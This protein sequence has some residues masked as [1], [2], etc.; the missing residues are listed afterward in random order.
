MSDTYDA[1]RARA[2]YAV[3]F[4][5]FRR[6]VEEVRRLWR[7]L[8]EE[9]ARATRGASGA[10]SAGGGSRGQ[11]EAQAAARAARESARAQETAAQAAARRRREE[12]QLSEALARAARAEQQ[13][14]TEAQ[15]T[16]RELE[17]TA[18]AA[19]RR[20]QAEER[21]RRLRERPAGPSFTDFL[22]ETAGNFGLALGAGAVVAAGVDA[23]RQALE[24]QRTQA[25]LR[26][27][28]T[29][30]ELYNETIRLAAE[31][32]R[33]FGGSLNANLAPLTSLAL[34]AQ[35][36]GVEIS[37]LNDLSQRL[38]L[39][40]PEQGADGAGVALREALSGDTQSLVE[41]FEL[42]RSALVAI[43]D[44][45]ATAAER[46][47]VVDQVLRDLNVT[48]DAVRGSIPQATLAFN[49]LNAELDTL[50]ITAGDGLTDA[51]EESAR[52][53]ARL[54]G[55]VNDNPQA[56][57]ELRALFGGGPVNLGG[58]ERDLARSRAASSLGQVGIG[59]DG[60]GG[61]GAGVGIQRAVQ[62]TLGGNA[63]I[64]QLATDISQDIARARTLEAS[65]GGGA[66]LQEAIDRS[67]ALI[68]VSDEAAAAVL[69]VNEQF[70]A[71]GDAE[72]YQRALSELEV[73][74]N[75]LRGQEQVV[76][77]I[78]AAST[79][80]AG[81]LSIGAVG[82]ADL[83]GRLTA[84]AGTSDANRLAVLSL[85]TGYR[86]GKLTA[87]ELAAATTALEQAQRQQAQGSEEA[88][89]ATAGLTE[90]QRARILAELEGE[91]SARQLA[92]AQATI[93]SLGGQVR[94]GLITAAEGADIIANR[95]GFAAD[96]AQRLIDRSAAAA[97]VNNVPANLRQYQS[98]GVPQ[99]VLRAQQ[100]SQESQRR[101]Q[102]AEEARR[103]QL[104]A[105][106]SA[107]DVVADRQRRYNEAV[108]QYG[109]R[110]AEAIR[111]E[112]AL[113]QARER[114]AAE[115]ERAA[116][117]GTSAAEKAARATATTLGRIEDRT[118]DHYIRLLQ[119]QEDF[120]RRSAR[121]QEDYELGRSRRQE[122]FETRRQRL[123][124]EGQIFEARQLEEEFRREEER[125]RQDFERDRAR[126]VDDFARQQARQAADLGLDTSRI[127]DR[128]ALR[129]VALPGDVAGGAPVVAPVVVPSGVLPESVGSAA[130]AAAA[131]GL[132]RV[133]FA[134]IS[135]QLDSETVATAVYPAIEQQLDAAL[136]GGIQTITVTAPPA[137]GQSS[138]V[139]GAR[140]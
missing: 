99:D 32:Q 63:G 15:R 11:S 25:T 24:L 96:E 108:K 7:R 104:L 81:D 82:A 127:A 69:R 87:D 6:D 3:D 129:G 41:R 19:S 126:E 36:T 51:L 33:L 74:F 49:E 61:S 52:G 56:I 75:N 103:E 21:E 92:N 134:P 95:F 48:T 62:A 130:P 139:S 79:Q 12:A 54:F 58:A 30:Q 46:L 71:T 90:Q 117:R 132:L 121:S 43:R 113:I 112:T 64:T 91:R 44:P 60:Q 97:R 26:A 1:G 131:L 78:G 106:G 101:I 84:L 100:A 28:I 111:A 42:S 102:E 119:Q 20:R 93:A 50:R 116:G 14:A 57:A 17:N 135:L 5:P 8:A 118:E 77:A 105:T 109:P 107:A 136:A 128:A 137:A 2:V 65:L 13:R 29:D 4:E 110:S 123:L 70:R 89:A 67:A 120:Q 18:A 27:T 73:R 40:S 98:T 86:D 9:Q 83:G 23:G 38:Q 125:A 140:P 133:E 94:Q 47:A 34:Q 45:A 66:A 22:G 80:L 55:L 39:L 85:A 115:A 138:G 10:P 76:A 68:Q 31:N 72:A 59:E 114:A 88:R 124:A 37:Q 122:D 53:L 35:A 16:A